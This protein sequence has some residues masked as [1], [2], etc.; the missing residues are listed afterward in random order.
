MGQ[1]FDLIHASLPEVIGGLVVAAIVA[2]ISRKTWRW[3]NNSRQSQDTKRQEAPI[4]FEILHRYEATYASRMR[5]LTIDF[6]RSAF[7]DKY[8]S[9]EEKL[10]SDEWALLREVAAFFEFTGILL[11]HKCVDREML[12]DMMYFNPRL[13][14]HMYETVDNMRRVY[15]PNQ[16]VNWQYL[17]EEEQKY[18]RVK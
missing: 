13:W 12:F 17:V 16:W 8:P 2:V 14:A 6:R 4:L 11:K 9:T 1:I 7:N 15:N 18:Y 10:N 3:W 5:L